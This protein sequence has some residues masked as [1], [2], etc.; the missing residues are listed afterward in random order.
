M[1]FAGVISFRNVSVAKQT[2]DTSVQ[3]NAVSSVLLF[4]RGSPAVLMPPGPRAST[5]GHIFGS[6]NTL[7]LTVLR[8]RPYCA[9]GS[10]TVATLFHFRFTQVRTLSD[11]RCSASSSLC[12]RGLRLAAPVL[13]L[14]PPGRFSASFSHVLAGGKPFTHARQLNRQ[15]LLPFTA[16]VKQFRRFPQVSRHGI[17]VSARSSARLHRVSH[18]VQ[19]APSVLF[20]LYG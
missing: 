12:C 10:L 8:L 6:V 14:P 11:R 3:L 1:L 5:G 20:P 16:A 15:C 7:Q 18:H 4:Q 13:V 2:G 19:P 9:F 17:P